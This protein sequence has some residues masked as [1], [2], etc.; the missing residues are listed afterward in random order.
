[1]GR[2]SVGWSVGH[3]LLFFMILFLPKY[4]PCPPARDSVAV[5]PTL[6][7]VNGTKQSYFLSR[8]LSSLIFFF[9][10]FSHSFFSFFLCPYFF[11][12]F[13]LF[14]F[15]PFFLP[16]FSYPVKPFFQSHLFFFL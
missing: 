11:L 9:F 2:R 4:G 16:F 10:L 5:Y 6:F 7:R 1:M 15:L 14:I 8:F 13:V 3:T 12:S